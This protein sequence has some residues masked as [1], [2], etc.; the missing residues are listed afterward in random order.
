MI[1]LPAGEFWIGSPE[2]EAGRSID[3]CRHRVTIRQPFAIGQYAVTFDEYD[4]F[5]VAEC[6]AKPADYED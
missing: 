6:R 3:E 1:T 5:C 2:N 4:R